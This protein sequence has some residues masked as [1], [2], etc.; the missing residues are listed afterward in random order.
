MGG[1]CAPITTGSGDISTAAIRSSSD[2]QKPNPSLIARGLPC[3]TR[4]AGRPGTSTTRYSG[5]AFKYARSA[6]LSSSWATLRVG[7]H[8]SPSHA[9]GTVSPSN[10]R[11]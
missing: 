6:A 8:Q 5:S 11:T 9:S 1:G 10:F 4:I 3:T 2:I 7:S